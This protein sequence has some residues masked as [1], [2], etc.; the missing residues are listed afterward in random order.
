MC[1]SAAEPKPKPDCCEPCWLLGSS[2]GVLLEREGR[3]EGRGEREGQWLLRAGSSLGHHS[4][5]PHCLPSTNKGDITN[6]DAVA[7]RP[8]H[9][10]RA[11]SSRGTVTFPLP[12]LQLAPSDVSGASA[13]HCS[14]PCNLRVIAVSGTAPRAHQHFSKECLVLTVLT[15]L[16]SRRGEKQLVTNAGLW[17]FVDVC[18]VLVFS[19][20]SYN[21]Y[22]SLWVML[23]E[24]CCSAAVRAM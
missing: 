16:H 23:V 19:I 9:S 5:L 1:D 6:K 11:D 20:L 10:G 18:M 7:L 22:A 14:Q 12:C 21:P 2:R 15:S 4:A 13:A 3:K 24:F 17:G 8:C